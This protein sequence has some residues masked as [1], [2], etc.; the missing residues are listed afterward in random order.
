MQTYISSMNDINLMDNLFKFLLQHRQEHLLNNILSK[1][2]R[3]ISDEEIN[4]VILILNQH[5]N[6]LDSFYDNKSSTSYLIKI[7]KYGYDVIS[8]T[9]SFSDYLTYLKL[10]KEKEIE[11]ENLEYRKLK[12]DVELGEQVVKDYPETKGRAKWAQWIAIVALL[13][14]AATWFSQLIKWLS[15][16]NIK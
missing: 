12:I 3:D 14:S 5:R 2:K 4:D 7:N 15:E 10:E 16:K 6:L 8:A 9:G 11:K 1:L 13:I